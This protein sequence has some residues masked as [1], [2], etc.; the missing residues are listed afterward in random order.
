MRFIREVVGRGLAI[1]AL[2][3][4]GSA[5]VAL[6]AA[7][8]IGAPATAGTASTHARPGDDCGRAP[9][10]RHAQWLDGFL[11]RWVPSDAGPLVTDF[12]YEWEEVAFR[13]RVWES[14]PDSDGA[15]Q[16]DLQVQ[17]LRAPTLSDP[18]ALRS[19]LAEYLE[20]D[21]A[22]WETRS[23]EHPDGPGFR[24]AD[25]L[26]WLA[27][28]GTA[29]RVQAGEQIGSRDLERTACAV[30]QVLGAR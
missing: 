12:E 1:V 16:V 22:D 6:P 14:G 11:L 24:D 13:S 4:G 19:F 2:V 20:R 26:F 10:P 9:A 5:A 21:P 25:E 18:A 29:V 7:A 27:A 3:A 8:E 28:P 17:V 15:Y 23:F 30:R